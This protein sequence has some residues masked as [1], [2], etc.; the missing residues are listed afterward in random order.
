[1][2]VL[3]SSYFNF[4]KVFINSLFK[5][6]NLS[7][8]NK[9]YIVDIGLT[10]DDKDFFNSYDKVEIYD[11]E[12]K[13][14]FNDGGTWGIGWQTSV[15]AKTIMFKHILEQTDLP[16][17][18]IDGDCIFV[19]DFEELI[20]ENYDIQACK[21][22]NP[23]VP[24]LASFVI[25]QNNSKSIDFISSW[26]DIM[27]NK[28]LSAPRESPS[29]GEAVNL[30]GDKLNFGSIDRIKVSTHNE[31]ELCDDTYIIHLKGASLSR[32]ITERE[33]KSLISNTHFSNLI[34][35]YMN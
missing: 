35:E 9:L 5:N 20:D 22:G 23:S 2:V 4:G 31:D 17:V 18:M 24:Y 12:L 8:L 33:L 1:M 11:T 32:D 27:S 25:A 16:L 21:R 7:N 29:L 14:D 19:K 10:D 15:G 6:V 13:T 28:P 26:I 34:E 3:N 30:V